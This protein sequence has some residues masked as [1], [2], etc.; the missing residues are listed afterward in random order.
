MPLILA[1]NGWQG[2]TNKS[3]DLT[4]KKAG[5]LAGATVH[6][7]TNDVDPRTFA[8]LAS[9]TEAAY[10]GYAAIAIA[11]WSANELNPDGTVTITATNVMTFTGPAAGGGPT[12][13]GYF[14]QSAGAGT[15][16]LYYARFSAPVNLTDNTKLLEMVATYVAR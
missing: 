6:L 7:F 14:V 1:D 4:A 11:G 3:A 13:Y 16:Y 8:T 15:P 12:V 10:A 2:Q 9:F 5:D